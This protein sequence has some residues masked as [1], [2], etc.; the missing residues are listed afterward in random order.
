MFYISGDAGSVFLHVYLY[1]S[2]IYYIL[3]SVEMFGA[4][5]FLTKNFLL[6]K[7]KISVCNPNREVEE[8]DI[9]ASNEKLF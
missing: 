8:N 3:Q 4:F 2:C 6:E 5:L 9:S 7:I 1:I